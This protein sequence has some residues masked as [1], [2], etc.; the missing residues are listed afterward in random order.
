MSTWKNKEHYLSRDKAENDV[1]RHVQLH[2]SKYKKTVKY[3][4]HY[5]KPTAQL[6]YKNRF[7]KCGPTCRRQ[8]VNPRHQTPQGQSV[9]RPETPLQNSRSWVARFDIVGSD[10]TMMNQIFWKKV[11]GQNHLGRWEIAECQ[12]PGI[13]MLL[14]TNTKGHRHPSIRLFIIEQ[15]TIS[16]GASGWNVV[17]A[18]TCHS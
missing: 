11:Q 2:V 12:I 17:N 5:V 3:T 7:P 1:S 8:V 6:L 18:F 13:K 14:E 9:A 16:K 4:I 15:D 10:G